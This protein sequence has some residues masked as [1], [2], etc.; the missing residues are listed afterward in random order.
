MWEDAFRAL[1]DAAIHTLVE[2]LGKK[3]ERRNT[4]W[5]ETFKLL[6]EAIVDVVDNHKGGINY[7]NKF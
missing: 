3:Q 2:K 7:V 5:K 6:V 4:M 1:A